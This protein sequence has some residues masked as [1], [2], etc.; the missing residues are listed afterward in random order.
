MTIYF[1]S[2]HDESDQTLIVRRNNEGIDWWLA[3]GEL[4]PDYLA[5][6]EEGNIPTKWVPE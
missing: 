4:D 6:V 2:K 3:L 1:V 5:W